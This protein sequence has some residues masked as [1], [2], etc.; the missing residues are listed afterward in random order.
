MNFIQYLFKRRRVYD[1]LSQEIEQHL[2]EKVD[3]LVAG[4]MSRQEA[5]DTARREFGNMTLTEE[6]GREVW[7]WATGENFL[8]DVRYALRMLR[9]NPGFTCVAILTLALGIGAN[10]AI[11]S[12]INAVLLR[13]LP[14]RDPQQLVVLTDPEE[15]GVWV[16]SSDGERI[17]LT[18][19]EFEG[20]RDQNEV[21]SG[22]FAAC[23]SLR[24]ANV[25]VGSNSSE[26][27][28][29]AKVSMVSGT[30]WSVLGVKP[31]E[32]TM[33][34]PEVDQ[35]LGAHP[36]AV[37]SYAF[38][39]RRMRQDRAAVGR[40]LR[41]RQTVFDI[42]GVMPPDFTGITVGE[43]PDIWVPIM[44]QQQIAPGSDWLTWKPG[45]FAK[46][47]FLQVVGRLKPGVSVEQARASINVTFQQILHF[48]AGSISSEEKKR[49]MFSNFIVLHNGSRGLSA[50]R[51][52][53]SAPLEVMMGLVGLLL[54]LAAANVANLLLARA[55]ARQREITLR[56]ALGAGRG[57][58]IR[59]LLTE[60]V[61]L[62]GIGGIVGIGLAYWADQLLLHM[63][64]TSPTAVPLDV[65]PD[66]SV[67]L[68]ALGVS[69]GTGILF[70]LAPALR[71]T[72]LNLSDAL[73]GSSR[74][75][76]GDAQGETRFPMGKLL[77]GAQ[78]A[79]SLLLL[80]SAGLFVRSLQKLSSV[81]LGYDPQGMLLFHMSPGVA[82]YKGAA[83]SQLYQQ[84]LPKFAAVPGVRG[85]T[86][87]DNGLFYGSD[88]EDPI[89]IAG[90]PPKAGQ[91]M[92]AHFDEIGPKYF[93]TIGIPVLAGRDVDEHDTAGAPACW[94]NQSFAKYFLGN[95]NP[96]GKRLN[97]D[98]R[99][100]K[101]GFEIV[102]VV[103]D[104]KSDDLHEETP[105]RFYMPYFHALDAPG[106]SFFEV[107]YGGNPIAVVAELR[108]IAREADST[109]DALDI[110]TIPQ[111]VDRGLV[112]DRLTARLSAFFGVLAL[113][114]ACI[115]LYGVLS[116]NVAR[117]TS[118]IGV[119]MAL[120]AQRR[121]VLRLV[122][123]DALLVT[124]IGAAVGLAAALAATRV[125]STLLFGLT[126]R[127]PATLAG[128]AAV[129]LIAGTVAACVPAWRASRVDPM[130]ALRHE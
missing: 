99:G 49:E 89:E 112:R 38:W 66:T 104:A 59:Q 117:R 116:Y 40:Q 26:V 129:L 114:L 69:L 100:T 93:A 23:S 13:T 60:S 28:S 37:I 103:A 33:F 3:E 65:H 98:Y 110:Q 128:S 62:A 9:Q 10:T 97:V 14:V 27:G 119:R 34:G 115:G 21:F 18:E 84:L 30:Y 124:G 118:E 46:T 76:S 19:H 7:R 127:D 91:D 35:G 123:A 12:V 130:T 64:S 47:M 81:P 24:T 90:Y 1:D 102:G 44:M 107:R 53:Y 58:L 48:E 96:I 52:E 68:F 108:R 87:S 111:L 56:V 36:V 82:G 67:L 106:S 95:E 126:P 31:L 39:Q 32:G 17:M 80:V 88:S 94:V 51:G 85:V 101:P 50:L 121:D 20:L 73:R 120:G 109:L 86:L 22:V 54:L 43:S 92:D 5:Q 77:V 74:S 8:M 72:R 55:N 79:I 105:R 61:L 25:S 83:V 57:R 122:L 4:G 6:R 75:I 63:V 78:V 70:G 16:G 2:R 11:F 41:V 15:E 125:L 45:A 113:V 71:A 42:V 29:P